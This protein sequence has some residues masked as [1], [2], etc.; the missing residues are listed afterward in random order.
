MA[1]RWPPILG[2]TGFDGGTRPSIS[3]ATLR[4]LNDNAGVSGGGNP[5]RP[6]VVPVGACCEE[7]SCTQK[8]QAACLGSGGT[9]LGTGIVCDP[10]P[11]PG[12]CCTDPCTCEQT[13]AG[14]CEGEFFPGE[15]CDPNPCGGCAGFDYSITVEFIGTM[16]CAS[17]ECDPE[18][19]TWAW[20]CS[21]TK[22]GH[23]DGCTATQ[24][25]FNEHDSGG[26][27]ES[28]T[29]SCPHGFEQFLNVKVGI[30]ELQG[31]LIFDSDYFLEAVCTECGIYTSA[32]AAEFG[33]GV[34]VP[35]PPAN[36]ND[37]ACDPAG[38]ACLGTYIL[39]TG[40]VDFAFTQEQVPTCCD[41]GM[42]GTVQL[43]VTIVLS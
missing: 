42:T 43:V 11:C 28:G 10:N 40:E 34:L 12:A 17:N 16:N 6:P 37:D 32:N 21:H 24:V 33:T 35:P 7:G 25:H 31:Q 15:P 29:E 1:K 22:T 2:V 5:I 18:C 3:L 38:C 30:S 8:T 39:D 26:C 9:W 20:D 14:D 19:S 4:T 23:H 27:E 13:T 41:D 36:F